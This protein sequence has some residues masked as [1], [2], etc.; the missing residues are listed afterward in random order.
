MAD[1]EVRN[2]DGTPQDDDGFESL[3]GNGSSDNNEEEQNCEDASCATPKHMPQINDLSTNTSCDKIK[4]CDSRKAIAG[5]FDHKRI[6]LS[7]SFNQSDSLPSDIKFVI[8]DDGAPLEAK[9]RSNWVKDLENFK[10]QN[11]CPLHKLSGE[12]TDA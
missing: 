2:N 7:V 6:D 1:E 4:S 9:F 8:E 10:D 12:S 3:N 5:D 11:A